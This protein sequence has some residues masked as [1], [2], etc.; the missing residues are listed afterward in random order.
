MSLYPDLVL[1]VVIG[2][3]PHL[4]PI[5]IHEVNIRLQRVTVRPRVIAIK[6]QRNTRNPLV[7]EENTIA[8]MI[9]VKTMTIITMPNQIMMRRGHPLLLMIDT[10]L[11]H[12]HGDL[13][14]AVQ[15]YLPPEGPDLLVT[16]TRVRI[17][18]TVP[19]R[20][21]VGGEDLGI[22]VVIGLI[23]ET[24]DT[25]QEIGTDTN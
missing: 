12:Q 5:K 7:K 16:A 6:D 11:H 22:V 17:D 14:H 10:P 15:I 18:G 9:M 1:V 13:Y 24:A 21:I 8:V 20:M 4:K 25:G 3:A 19:D 2:K 23:R